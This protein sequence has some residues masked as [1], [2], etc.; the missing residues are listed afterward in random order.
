MK[1]LEEEIE[2]KDILT[3]EEYTDLRKHVSS[4][5][6]DF[7]AEDAQLSVIESG[8]PRDILKMAR[9]KGAD[10]KAL[11]EAMIKTGDLEYIC[12]FAEKIKGA[13][14]TKLARGI[15]K[16]GDP[17][18]IYEFARRVKRAIPILQEGIIAAGD[19]EYMYKLATAQ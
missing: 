10:I 5:G 6:F 9:V 19:P 13:N 1:N 7:V 3:K 14:R 8:N 12:L 11:E 4:N 18:Y 15:V 17:V 16:A 2:V